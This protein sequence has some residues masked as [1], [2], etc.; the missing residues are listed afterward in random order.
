MWPILAMIAASVVKSAADQG[1]EN[2][3]RETA[4]ETTRYSPWTGMKGQLPAH[5][6]WVG[7]AM[8]GA[9]AGAMLNGATGGG[10]TPME[11]NGPVASGNAYGKFLAQQQ[12]AAHGISQA[13]NSSPWGNYA[14]LTQGRQAPAMW[15]Y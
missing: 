7:N 11:G 12:D 14:S 13:A 1:N 3:D 2:K 5:T 6:P 9:M 8:Q 10:S 4:A 15:Q